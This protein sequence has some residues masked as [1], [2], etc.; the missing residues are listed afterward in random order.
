MNTYHQ[1]SHPKHFKFLVTIPPVFNSRHV[2]H[3]WVE[4]CLLGSVEAPNSWRRGGKEG[5]PAWTVELEN[6]FT[7]PFFYS[8][9]CDH[10]KFSCLCMQSPSPGGA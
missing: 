1:T 8:P 10:S 6:T 2:C 5:K 4:T 7:K 9:S 3:G